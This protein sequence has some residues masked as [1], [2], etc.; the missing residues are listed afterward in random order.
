M[1]SKENIVAEHI[2]RET[3]ALQ[4]NVYEKEEKDE[5]SKINKWGIQEFLM[6]NIF[7]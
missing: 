1:Y 3:F 7:A 5:T 2:A 6:F 4:S